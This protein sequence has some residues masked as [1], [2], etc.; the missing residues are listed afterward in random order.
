MA[1]S[2]E[3]NRNECKGAVPIHTWVLISNFKLA[4]N[5]LRRADGTF[6][7][8]LAE[9]LDRRV[10]PDARAQEGV[11]SFDHVIDTSTG[12]EV[13][14]YRGAAAA[15]NGAAG[16]G[17]VTLPILDFLAGAPSPDPFP[18]ILFFHG[19]SFAHSSSGTA[20][21]DNLCRRFVK[22]SK[23]VV[24]SVNYRRAPE[25]RYPCAYEDGW[26]ALKWAMSQPFLRSGADARP[27][28]FLSGDSSGGNIA[29][30]VAVRAAD[31]GI[32][33]CGNIL[34]NAMFGGTERTESERRLDGKY[35]VTLQD[36]DWYWKAY[37]PEDTDRDHPACNPFGP[38]G[39]RLRG[40]PFTKSLII[41]SG[42]D[43]TCDRQ[44]A[45]AEGLQEDGHHVKLVYREK[46]TIGFYLLSNTDHYHEVMEEIADFLRANL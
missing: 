21:Y 12:L 38:N 31:A 10:P 2:D 25:H 5:M 23:G 8:D 20:I 3:V 41:V 42:L 7:R 4:Y 9:F 6:D 28:V 1:G 29:H 19:G 11:S 24:V 16:A 44:L 34:L 18:V 45:Y 14:I 32:S 30:H 26:T 17:A 36:R 35:F 33:I 15:N 27:R 37:L 22:L 40:L 13:R 43:L 39:R 46:A